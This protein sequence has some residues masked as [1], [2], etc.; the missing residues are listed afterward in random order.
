MS[1]SGLTGRRIARAIARAGLTERP[2]KSYTTTCCTGL[3]QLAGGAEI[4]LIGL[5]GHMI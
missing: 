1:R 4:G 5:Y 2:G 3:D